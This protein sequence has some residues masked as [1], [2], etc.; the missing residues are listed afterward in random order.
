MRRPSLSLLAALLL[1]AACERPHEPN[2]SSGALLYAN[3]CASCHGER[4]EGDGPLRD[5]LRVDVPNLRNLSIRNA[6]RFPEE[7]V[8][9][10]L[11]GEDRVQAHGDGEMPVWGNTFGRGR[12][13]SGVEPEESAVRA[14]AVVEYLRE[15]QYR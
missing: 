3:H 11:E 1:A 10:L 15:V 12:H 7:R 5:L 9:A 4:A 8:R 2:A 13:G 14:D 6:G